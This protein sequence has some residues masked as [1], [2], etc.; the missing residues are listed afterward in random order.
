MNRRSR[1][2]RALLRLAFID[3]L[4][5]LMGYSTMGFVAGTV[6]YMLLLNLGAMK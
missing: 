1:E 3:S 2:S 4:T 6:V 5:V